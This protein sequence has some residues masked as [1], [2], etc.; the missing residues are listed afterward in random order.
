MPPMTM[1][2]YFPPGDGPQA[3][4]TRPYALPGEQDYPPL[5]PPPVFAPQST[6]MMF[7]GADA[8]AGLPVRGTTQ[9]RGPGRTLAILGAVVVVAALGGGGVYLARSGKLNVGGSSTPAAVVAATTYCTALKS[10]NYTQAYGQFDAALHAIISAQTYASVAKDIDTQQGAVSACTLGTA[11]INGTSATIPATITRPQ[12]GQIQATWQLAASGGAWR[13]TASPEPSL[14]ARVAVAMYCADLTSA[15]YSAAFTLFA[16]PLQQELISSNDY[17]TGANDED[18][19]AGKAS[20]C[21]TTSVVLHPD[22]TA[23]A[24]LSVQR[25]QVE[26]DSVPVAAATN[27]LPAITDTPD[28]SIPSRAVSNAFCHDLITN[29]ENAA[30]QLFTPSAQQQIGSASNFSSQVSNAEILT[31]PITKCHST[32]FSLDSTDMSGTLNGILTT[33][34]ILGATDRNVVLSMV[35]VIA[36][37]WR[38][39]NATVDG[40]SI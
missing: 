21:G 14:L 36:M 33:Q 24:Q 29:N 4:L 25:Q 8:T 2:P 27:M 19:A 9:R 7:S 18:S 16:Q 12:G 6:P 11:T 30:F 22:G 28:A 10:A 39:D 37:Q 32:T 20:A 35:E 23:V 15:N 31:G 13:F 5:P 34:N 40:I 26:T 3:D 38:I 17:T 1:P